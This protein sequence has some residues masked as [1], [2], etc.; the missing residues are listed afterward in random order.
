MLTYALPFSLDLMVPRHGLA[1]V[2]VSGE[3]DMYRAPAFEA[4][5]TKCLDEG[6]RHMVLDLGE[7]S[8]IDSTALNVI[9]GAVPRLT[10][11][12]GSLNVL[13]GHA[14]VRRV[15]EVTSLDS[16]FGLHQV[17]HRAAA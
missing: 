17:R 9:V 1:V 15:F 13:Y 11:E 6:A 8:F 5:M 14:N 7:V 16:V 12:R 2:T 4:I 3:L 10:Q